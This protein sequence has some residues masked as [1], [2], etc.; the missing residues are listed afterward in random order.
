MIT[1]LT[2]YPKTNPKP[3]K[4]PKQKTKKRKKTLPHHEI[5]SLLYETRSAKSRKTQHS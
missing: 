3:K 2:T 5:S 4:T 1:D